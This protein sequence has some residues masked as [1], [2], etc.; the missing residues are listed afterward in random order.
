MR[1]DT[2]KEGGGVDRAVTFFNKE[3]IDY[4]GW[5]DFEMWQFVS[6]FEVI[7]ATLQRMVKDHGDPNSPDF[8]EVKTI[9]KRLA[10]LL[11]IMKTKKL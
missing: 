3:E 10:I 9:Q 6:Y 2:W 4:R 8:Q 7:Y 1:Y 5:S 11:S